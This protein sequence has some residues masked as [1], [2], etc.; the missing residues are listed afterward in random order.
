MRRT[1]GVVLLV[2]ALAAGAACSSDDEQTVATGVLARAVEQ[3]EGSGTARMAMRMRMSGFAGQAEPLDLEVMQG[4][5][6]F[7]A[8][9]AQL[10]MD[11][12]SLLQRAGAPP[13][14][15]E[16]VKPLEMIVDGE[17]LYMKARTEDGFPFVEVDPAVMGAGVTPTG[18]ADP[19]EA[20]DV[21]RELAGEPQT[22]GPADVRGTPTTQYH[23]TIPVEELAPD[24]EARAPLEEAGIESVPADAFVDAE[25]RLRRMSATVDLSGAP[26]GGTMG[27]DVDVFEFGVATAIEV[28]TPDQVSPAI[29]DHPNELMRLLR[30][31][32]GV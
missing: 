13:E 20:L 31:L 3:V 10:T 29:I 17:R 4:V 27:F 14:V 30:H 6:D 32:F 21:L 23:F 11:L 18:S 16:G 5:V 19:S 28:P 2:T 15:L 22:V 12:R 7:G 9:R 1:W 8:E 24:A 26:G 25:G